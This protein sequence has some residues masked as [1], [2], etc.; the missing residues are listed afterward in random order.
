M[1]KQQN[2]KVDLKDKSG[3]ED[4]MWNSLADLDFK[5]LLNELQG[6]KRH[7]LMLSFL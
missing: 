6:G 1:R 2:D 3:T 5:K 7:L 4:E